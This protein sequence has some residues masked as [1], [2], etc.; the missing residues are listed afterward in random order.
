MGH[1]V[2]SRR[3]ATELE[4]FELRFVELAAVMAD[5]D[6]WTKILL[7]AKTIGSANG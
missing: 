5:Y 1:L 7:T 6:R 4:R 2:S 3:M